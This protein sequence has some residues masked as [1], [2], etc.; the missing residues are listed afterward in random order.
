[1]PE[2]TIRP[3]DHSPTVNLDN[4][5]S[6]DESVDTAVHEAAYEISRAYP[7]SGNGQPPVR[8]VEVTVTLFLRGNKKYERPATFQEVSVS[9]YTAVKNAFMPERGVSIATLVKELRQEAITN[10]ASGWQWTRLVVAPVV[11]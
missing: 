7:W 9:D 4:E 10:G 2:R 11:S 6:L 3:G 8:T 5:D 1:M